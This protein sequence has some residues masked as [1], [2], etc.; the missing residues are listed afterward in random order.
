MDLE[1]YYVDPILFNLL[2]NQFG[3]MDFPQRFEFRCESRI[4]C[5]TK[6]SN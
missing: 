5:K 4:K 1:T 6:E 2:I 3:E